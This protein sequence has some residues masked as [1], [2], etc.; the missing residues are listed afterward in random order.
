M[1]EVEAPPGQ[2]RVCG[3]S[4]ARPLVAAAALAC[5]HLQTFAL[6]YRCRLFNCLMCKPAL[7]RQQ[8]T[9]STTGGHAS[10]A[11]APASRACCRPHSCCPPC[12]ARSVTSNM[13]AMS[14][15]F[16]GS[17]LRPPAKRQRLVNRG[18]QL[19][20]LASADGAQSEIVVVGA[21]AAGLTAAHFAAVS[22]AK[23]GPACRRHCRSLCRGCISNLPACCT[24]VG[25]CRSVPLIRRCEWWRRRARLVR[26]F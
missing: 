5:A 15:C 10:T 18:R 19:C 3:G 11:P 25:L 23:V 4:V 14:Q 22:G 12:M 6:L 2:E 1:P 7:H 20:C 8:I 13:T 24:P 26:R 17:A 21:G 16:T 9:R